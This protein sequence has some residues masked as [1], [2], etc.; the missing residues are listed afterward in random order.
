MII[1][2]SEASDYD[3][4]RRRHFYRF[5][6]ELTPKENPWEK[7]SQVHIGLETYYKAIQEHGWGFREEAEALAIHTVHMNMVNDPTRIDMYRH[8]VDMLRSYFARWK[9]DDFEILVVEKKY[10]YEISSNLTMGFT[11]DMIIR[12]VSGP[13]AGKIYLVDHKTAYNFWSDAMMRLNPQ[14]PKYVKGLRANGINVDGV[15]LNQ[16]RT[17][18]GVTD[19]AK[20][21]RREYRHYTD[22]VIETRVK[23]FIATVDEIRFHRLNGTTEQNARR[24]NNAYECENK[25]FKC[26]FQDVCRME[27]EGKDASS[28]KKMYFTKYSNYSYGEKY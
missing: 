25:G 14:F 2:G 27:L 18:E 22:Q 11:V 20:R 24:T 17:R 26:V 7:G 15:I 16:L 28:V 13:D 19:Q 3:T 6:Q 8:A 23:E 12:I 10:K 5:E 9:D 21:N 4:C 1:S